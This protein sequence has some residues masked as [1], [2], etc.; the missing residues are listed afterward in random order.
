[1]VEHSHRRYACSTHA[2]LAPGDAT[3]HH[4]WAIHS[5]PPNFAGRTRKA[6]PRRP[7]APETRCRPCRPR[8]PTREN[9]ASRDHVPSPAQL[10]PKVNLST[11]LCTAESALRRPRRDRRSR[12]HSSTET[13]SSSRTT[14]RTKRAPREAHRTTTAPRAARLPRGCGRAR[15]RRTRRATRPGCR[16]SGARGAGARRALQ[17]PRRRRAAGRP[18][19]RDIQR[20]RSCGARRMQRA[21]RAAQGPR[22][23]SWTSGRWRERQTQ[24]APRAARAVVHAFVVS[25]LFDFLDNGSKGGAHAFLPGSAPQ[26]GRGS[27]DGVSRITLCCPALHN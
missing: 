13:H 19:S 26:Q 2:P 6:R 22:S 25:G 23:Q 1:M 24:R 14:P 16:P 21:R 9:D 12:S 5:A 4:G 15:T 17:A 3:A 11:Q 8:Q 20:C 18:P 10:T 27:N 7:R